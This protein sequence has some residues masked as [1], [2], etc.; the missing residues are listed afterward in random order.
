MHDWHDGIEW[1]N[2]A[3]FGAVLWFTKLFKSGCRVVWIDIP[4][5]RSVISN[6]DKSNLNPHKFSKYYEIGDF[7][8]VAFPAVLEL[9]KHNMKGIVS[10]YR[11]HFVVR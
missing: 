2:V 6:S 10:Q 8:D 9:A 7:R 1:N 4:T 5:T 11:R 3:K